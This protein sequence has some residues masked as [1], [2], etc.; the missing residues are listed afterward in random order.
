LFATAQSDIKRLREKA[1]K[2]HGN[3]IWHK[4]MVQA[5]DQEAI[6]PIKQVIER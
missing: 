2:Q 4:A 3:R 5:N 6:E 1:L